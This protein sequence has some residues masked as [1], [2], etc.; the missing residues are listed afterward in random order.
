MLIVPR[1]TSYTPAHAVCRYP[2]IWDAMSGYAEMSV[3]FTYDKPKAEDMA[4]AWREW[5]WTINIGGPA[6]DDPGGEFIPGK[7]TK[8][9]VTITHRGCIRDCSWCYIPDREGKIRLLDIKPGNILNDNNILAC[10]KDHQRKVF[11][12]LKTQS[13]VNFKGGLDA[14][15]LTEWA[16]DEIRALRLDELYLAYDSKD[17]KHSLPAIARCR[18]AGIPQEKIRCYVMIGNGETIDQA[19]ERCMDVLMGG[20]MPFAQLYDRI[21]TPDIKAWKAL[22]RKWSRPAIYRQFIRSER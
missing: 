8:A 20:G 19:E 14:R 2:V 9:G 12:M 13:R 10:P 21:E 22:A 16:I 5:G 11:E 4:Q 3:V 15:L 6:Y 17:N 7:Y 18:R 1:I